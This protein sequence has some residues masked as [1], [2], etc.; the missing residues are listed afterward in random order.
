MPAI[1]RWRSTKRERLR[2]LEIEMTTEL[3][4]KIPDSLGSFCGKWKVKELALFGSV[5]RS[6]FRADSDIDVLTTFAADANWSLFDIVR[7]REELSVLLGREV[8]LVQPNGLR[9][10]FRRSE[11]LDTREVIYAG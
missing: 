8:D 6:D 10:P 11:I 9:N 7:M 4:I 3:Q 2:T 5:L 1:A